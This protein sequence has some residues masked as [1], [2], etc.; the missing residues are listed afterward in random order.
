VRVRQSFPRDVS[1]VTRV[2][3]PGAIAKRS[4]L[5]AEGRVLV[6]R[7]PAMDRMQNRRIHF[8]G[9]VPSRRL[10]R[11]LGVDLV[12]FKTCTY[13]CIYCQLGRTTHRT[14]EVREY[15][16]LREL[17]RELEAAFQKGVEADYVTLSGS[18]EPTLHWDIAEVIR[19][20]KGLTPIP[21]AVLTNG[22]LLYRSRMRKQL[23]QADL[24]IPFFRVVRPTWISAGNQANR[25]P[26]LCIRGVLP[27]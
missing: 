10:G 4:P 1:G 14:C 27:S 19:M 26:N 2:S 5:A 25:Q 24:I 7:S 16:T 23:L 12:P 22:P 21:V 15:V 11:S 20:I 6:R 8:F 13:N 9:P 3:D 18:G 17:H